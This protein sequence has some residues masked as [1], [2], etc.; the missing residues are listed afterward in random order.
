MAG[1]SFKSDESFLEKL[2][3]GTIGTRKV[4]E[5]LMASGH[6]PIELERGSTGYKIWKSIKI[7]RI[8][9]PDILCVNS[10]IRIESRAKTKLAISMSHSQNDPSRGWDHG[11]KDDDYTAFVVCSKCGDEPIDWMAQDLVQYIKVT[12][13][14]E[15][16]KSGRITEERRKGAEEGSESRLTWPSAIASSDGVVSSVNN[17]RIQFKRISDNRIISLQLINKKGVSLN[18]MF[19]KGQ[20]IQKNTILASVVPV[21]LNV[22]ATDV[23]NSHY[24]DLLRS[25]S[26]ADRYTAAKALSHLDES[27]DDR[28]KECIRDENEH[29]Y[30][31]LEI[32]ATLARKGDADGFDFIRSILN[33]TYLPYRLEAIIILG[34]IPLQKSCEILCSVLRDNGQSNNVRAGA[35]WA[36]G[37]INLESCIPGLINAFNELDT[38]IRIEAARALRKLADSYTRNVVSQ[39][40]SA[41]E[42]VRPGIAWALGKSERWKFEQLVSLLGSEAEPDLRYWIAYVIGHA[43]QSRMIQDIEVLRKRDSEIYF[44]VT[45]L[46]KLLD[47]WI[48]GL[49]EY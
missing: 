18:P 33:D 17:S 48:Y 41:S 6:S 36:L 23:D 44:A 35:A 46:W 2:A 9:V 37:E 13:L 28:L 38:G 7:K 3:I 43:E 16:F 30:V 47:S 14:R 4:M 32:A 8:R 10:G 42:N 12:D 5:S 25:S 40:A 15:A 34:E 20:R 49:K 27:Y 39:F 26:I 24:L 1:M 22:E 11:L 31:R 45:L 29:I 19:R 21:H